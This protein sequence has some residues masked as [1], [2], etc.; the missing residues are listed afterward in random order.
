MNLERIKEL[1]KM[2][3]E[4]ALTYGECVEIQE[5]F[6]K[7]PDSQ[8]MDLRDN[9]MIDDMLEELELEELAKA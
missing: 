8:L 9:A 2:S 4:G 3:D 1:K 7:L 6:D 5:A